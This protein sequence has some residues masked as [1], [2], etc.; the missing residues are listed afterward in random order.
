MEK[1]I[2]L[3]LDYLLLERHRSSHT[4]ANYRLDLQMFVAFAQGLDSAMTWQTV[5]GDII[6]RWMEAMMDA[7][8][9]ASS[10]NRR[11]S[12]LRSFFRFALQRG[13]LAADP[14]YQVRGP[15]KAKV[16]PQYL[17]EQEMDR[18]LRD[19]MWGDTFA[20]TRARTLI[21]LFYSTG[22]RLSELTGLDDD[23]IDFSAQQVK[24]L[25]KRNK[26]RVVPFGAELSAALAAYIALRDT[27]LPRHTTALF[28]DDKGRRI[29]NWKV[30][31]IVQQHL[32]KVT[33]MKKR[34]PHVLRHTFATAMLNNDAALESIRALLGHESISTTE[35]YTHTTFEQLRRVY[36]H[37]HPRGDAQEDD[38]AAEEK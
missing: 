19:E 27:T 14:S 11:L 31:S 28:V 3:F 2:S 8:G 18:L 4:I 24:V 33:T 17:Q 29:A 35:I 7:G 22:I 10:V 26:E 13:I 30:R 38:S 12:S 32:A 36:A 6:R 25:G 34:S 21:L 1:L 5:D 37:T 15:K 23:D 9:A 20:D 16:L